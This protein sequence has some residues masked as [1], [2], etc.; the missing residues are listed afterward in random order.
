[1]GFASNSF[2]VSHPGLPK[3]G[4]H[5]R[6]AWSAFPLAGC[7]AR[8]LSRYLKTI[9][10]QLVLELRWWISFGLLVF[11]AAASSPVASYQMRSIGLL[12]LVE[13]EHDSQME[14]VGAVGERFVELTVD[15]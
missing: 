14:R 3:D 13:S 4:R 6:G 11:Q 7:G 10:A 9:V 1:M 2:S 12:C 15:A 8:G 5:F